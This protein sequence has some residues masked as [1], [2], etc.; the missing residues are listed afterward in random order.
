M[1]VSGPGGQWKADPQPTW[2]AQQAPRRGWAPMSTNPYWNPQGSRPQA[3]Q[4][5]GFQYA[6]QH[7]YVPRPPGRGGGS[8]VPL[9]LGVVFGAVVLVSFLALLAGTLRSH[10]PTVTVP[11]ETSTRPSSKSSA[12]S[13]PTTTSRRTQK[14]S[15]PPTS[16]QTQ[17][18]APTPTPTPTL[19]PEPKPR[20][21]G[22]VPN[23]KLD[24]LPAPDSNDPA[25]K[26]VQQA[27]IYNLSW[28]DLTGCPQA[29]HADSMAEMGKQVEAGIEC[30]QKAW[31]PVFERLGYS[32]HSVPVYY[33]EG[34][35]AHSPCGSMQAPAMYCSANGGSLYF[36]TKLLKDSAAASEIWI[37][38][39]VF[40]EYGH[41]IQSLSKVQTVR[42]QL[43]SGNETERRIEIQAE[44]YATGM[45]R[46]D[47][48]FQLTRANYEEIRE[49]LQSFVDDG[50]HGT[51][52][53]L[54]YWGMR[55]FH[56][57]TIGGCNTWVVGSEKVR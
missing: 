20:R 31:K 1:S 42:N 57:E 43:P 27:P 56:S 49:S 3:S 11:H 50:I 17:A 46:S 39:M 6:P 18:P 34:D 23:E 9:A 30:V 16:R 41:H 15:P 29:S 45:L 5:F 26:T 24:P 44:C 38:L 33:F 25:W 7:Q 52:E 14:S 48:S 19:T 54:L 2:G 35:T 21:A 55:G 8:N 28:P 13:E 53:S 4:S 37:K 51:P 32:T 22:Q 36:G 40:H 12:T 47:D 10:E